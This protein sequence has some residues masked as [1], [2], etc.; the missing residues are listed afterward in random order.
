MEPMDKIIDVLVI[1]NKNVLRMC[2]HA[3]NPPP[4]T[5]CDMY[6]TYISIKLMLSFLLLKLTVVYLF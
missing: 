1:E 4:L 6:N 2:Q 3:K 5:R